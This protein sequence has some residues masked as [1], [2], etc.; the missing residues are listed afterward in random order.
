VA[1]EGALA[2]PG[3]RAVEGTAE[4][5]VAMHH[6]GAHKSIVALEGALAVRLEVGVPSRRCPE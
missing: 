6:Q 4:Q 5:L 1:F 3:D 2:R